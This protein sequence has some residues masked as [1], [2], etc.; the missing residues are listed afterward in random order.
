[1]LFLLPVFT[2]FLGAFFSGIL[3]DRNLRG[4]GKPKYYLVFGI[5]FISSAVLSLKGEDLF[6]PFSSQK[7]SFDEMK[8][9]LFLSFLCGLQ[10]GM[11]TL[12]SK[13]I[14][15]TTHVTG[16]ITDLGI[17]VSRELAR[18]DLTELNDERRSNLMR[19][20]IIV[21]F[22][23]G[24]LIGFYTFD[25]YSFAGF[26]IPAL[27]SGTLFGLTLFFQLIKKT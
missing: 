10:N 1:M 18:R 13:A 14:V 9:L 8:L 17:G 4:K 25:A 27:I 20:G 3:I 11:I 19:I 6:G 7:G 5:L 22:F 16:L 24:S 15:R 2:F 26:G 21:F 23:F 12:V